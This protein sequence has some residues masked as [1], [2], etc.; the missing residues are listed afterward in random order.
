MDMV[1]Y[2]LK[3]DGA[4]SKKET[5]ILMCSCTV[6]YSGRAESYLDK[7]DRIIMIKQDSTLLVHQY[8][9]NNPINYMKAE[10]SHFVSLT[11]GML[12]LSSKNVAMKEYMDII[13]DKVYCLFSRK[14]ED[15]ETIMIQGTEEDMAEMIY[16]NPELIEDGFKPLSREEHTQF[17]FIDVF[18]HDKNNVLVVIECKRFNADFNAVAQL[19]RYVGRI[20]EA[21]GV[22]DVRGVI[23]APHISDNA[24]AMLGELG[25]EFRQV[26]PPKYLERFNKSQTNLGQF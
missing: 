17:G 25:F 11:D 4:L 1:D 14:L 2:A 3:F 5:I 6:R 12:H 18:G 26:E 13:I 20:K 23:A 8:D 19:Q 7:G 21:K 22:A 16:S 9:T 15:S 10:S 24:K